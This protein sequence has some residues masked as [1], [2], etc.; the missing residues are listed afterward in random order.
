MNL[1]T[2]RD[3]AGTLGRGHLSDMKRIDYVEVDL[4]GLRG[5]SAGELEHA[6]GGPSSNRITITEVC[7]E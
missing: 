2:P 6:Q 5:L 1:E 4:D 3:Q 7:S